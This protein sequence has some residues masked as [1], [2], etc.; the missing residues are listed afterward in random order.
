MNDNYKKIHLCHN[1]TTA[2]LV[3]VFIGMRDMSCVFKDIMTY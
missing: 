3:I 2:F 1:V